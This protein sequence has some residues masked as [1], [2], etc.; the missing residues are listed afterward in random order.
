MRRIKSA[1]ANIAEMVNRKKQEVYKPNK[2]KNNNDIFCINKNKVF[3]QGYYSIKEP[4]NIKINNIKMLNTNIERTTNI[5]NDIVNDTSN[6]SFE[7]TALVGILL[8]LLNNIFRKNKFKDFVAI[9]IQNFVKYCL[10]FYIHH[11]VL[12]DYIEKHAS[13]NLIDYIHLK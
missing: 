12:N 2:I 9:L 7:E 8:N 11:Y 3:K 10:M 13:V 4:K 6:L 5:L 1:P